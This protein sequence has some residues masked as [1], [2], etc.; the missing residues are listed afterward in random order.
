MEA[1][2]AMPMN[3]APVTDAQNPRDPKASPAG[4][5]AV[6][7]QA[8]RQ[9]LAALVPGLEDAAGDELVGAEAAL[10]AVT[11]ETA[12][13]DTPVAAD[14]ALAALLMNDTA[15]QQPVAVAVP[16]QAAP[17]ATPADASEAIE[18]EA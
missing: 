11:E 18:G 4:D 6:F 1:I 9:E 2:P 16:V 12:L 15:L 3:T 7:G 5:G 10:E 8:L 17:V 13:V 14:P